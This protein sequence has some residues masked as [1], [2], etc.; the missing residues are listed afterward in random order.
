MALQMHPNPRQ[1]NRHNLHSQERRN[2]PE[3]GTENLLEEDQFLTEINLANLKSSSGE[4]QEYWLVA[5]HAAREAGRLRGIQ[6][7]IQRGGNSIDRGR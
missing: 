3:M 5:I 4:Q 6:P 1:S 2:P 7:P